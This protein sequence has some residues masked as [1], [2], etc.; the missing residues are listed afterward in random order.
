MLYYFEYGVLNFFDQL[1]WAKLVDFEIL[2]IN[3]YF[4]KKYSENVS[5]LRSALHG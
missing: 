3:R 2:G 5:I 1:K 4:S